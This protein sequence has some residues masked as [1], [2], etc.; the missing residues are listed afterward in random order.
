[1]YGGLTNSKR[2]LAILAADLKIGGELWTC[3]LRL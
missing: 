3:Q 1:M 2:V